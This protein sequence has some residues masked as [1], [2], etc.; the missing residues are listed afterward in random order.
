MAAFT[1]HS[2]VCRRIAVLL[3]CFGKND[4]IGE[5][6]SIVAHSLQSAAIA[7]TMTKD[8]EVCVAA[9]LHDLGHALGM[10]AG[11]ALGMNGCGIP[12][13]EG[14]GERFVKML[15]FTERVQKL[16]KNHVTGE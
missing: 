1:S 3:E 7:S 2:A 13:H 8:E 5:P 14:I 12:D 11:F 4:Y 6:V 9:L 16:V 15:G 10:E